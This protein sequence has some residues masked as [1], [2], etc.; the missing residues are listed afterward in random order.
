MPSRY[1]GQLV[2]VSAERL[3]EQLL[4]AWNER[5]AHGYANLFET[6]GTLVGFDGSIVASSSAIA[7]HLA[8]IFDDHTP[9]IYVGIVREARA[10]AD[11]V[12]LLRAEA[13]M[14][15]SGTHDI[16]PQL[17]TVHLLVAVEAVGRW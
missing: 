16:D 9:A 11:N 17:N 14:V 2:T 8:A 12:V 6:D 13:G 3:Y 4:D 5:D 7:D 15:P 10:L 1:N